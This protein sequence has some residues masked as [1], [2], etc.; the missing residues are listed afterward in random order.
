MADVQQQILDELR[1][2]NSAGGSSRRAAPS[3]PSAAQSTLGKFAEK[4]LTEL[5]GVAKG[6]A[7]SMVDVSGKFITGGA[8]ISDVSKALEANFKAAGYSGSTLGKILGSVS[9]GFNEVVKYVEEGVDA[10]RML[11][12]SGAS[13]D[14]SIIQLRQSAAN[15]RLTLDE[16]AEV[17]KNNT[18]LLASFGG[19]VNQ[20]RK[21]F[22]TLAKGLFDSGVADELRLMGY[23]NKDLNELIALQVTS[24]RTRDKL[25]GEVLKK[26]VEAARNLA[27]EMDSIAKLTGQT[28][29]EQEDKLRK[30]RE[31]GQIMAAIDAK[32]AAGGAHV[33]KAFDMMTT[34]AAAAGPDFQRLSKEIFAMGR[35]SQEMATKFSLLGGEAQKLMFQAA[36]EAAKGTEESAK[37]AKQ[38]TMEA[39]AAASMAQ[40]SETNRSLA[41]Q[42]VK[43]FSDLYI[44][45]RKYQQQLEAVAKQ[46]GLDLK[47]SEG[48]RQA[49][50][51]L[52]KQVEEE[53]KAGKDNVTK[54]AIL[55]E[56]RMADTYAAINNAL[57]TPLM[58]E[59]NPKLKGFAEELE[60]AGKAVNK[61][62]GERSGF[63]GTVEGGIEKVKDKVTDIV[64]EKE[65]YTKPTGPGRQPS[66]DR[67]VSTQ[68]SSAADEAAK[69]A[70][71]Y[72]K[73]VPIKRQGGSLGETGKLFENWGSGTLVELHG[74]ESVMK[75]ED[76]EKIVG[77]SLGAVKKTMSEVSSSGGIDVSKISKDIST[78]IS[79]APAKQSSTSTAPKMPDMG[80]MSVSMAKMGLKDDQK[81]VFD[82][83]MSLNA[84]QS[85]EKL[86][87]LK[88]EN[89]AAKKANK[90]A[91]DAR[92]VIEEKLEKEGKGIKD[93][94]GEDKKR[95]DE[96]TKQMNDSFEATKKTSDAIKIAERAEQTKQNLQKLGYDTVIKQEEDKGK[97][98]EQ[99]SEKIK[100]DIKEALPVNE[101]SEKRKEFEMTVIPQLPAK[102]L[103]GQ[104]AEAAKTLDEHGKTTLKYAMRDSD[105][106]IAAYKDGAQKTLNL[107][108]SN[109][110]EKN[111][112]ISDLE[113]KGKT[114][115]LS[116]REKSRIEKLKTE[117]QG[118]QDNNKYREQEIAAYTIAQ[119][120]K[121]K[122]LSSP[123][124][125]AANQEQEKTSLPKLNEV[126]ESASQPKTVDA[127]TTSKISQ[128]INNEFSN[129]A[130][131]V[132]TAAKNI[133][134]PAVK[135]SPKIDTKEPAV[136]E[137]DTARENARFAR[138]AES[139]KEPAVSEA[140]TA[141]ENARFA[142]QAE[143]SKLPAMDLNAL[144]LPGINFGIRSA[145]ATVAPA[146][147]KPVTDPD[148][149]RENA[150]IARQ[151]EQA[152]KSEAN[153]A[154]ARPPASTGKATL[155][156]VV[157]KLDSL[158]SNMSRLLEQTETL[159]KKQI[160]ATRANSQ[161]LFQR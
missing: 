158:N 89:E 131:A 19:T 87:S 55:A 40:A 100:N 95:F 37:R 93:L 103:S 57:V 39:A 68:E 109:I 156:D 65:E 112:Q 45:T 102:E 76:L 160:N 159:G 119:E 142:R 111:K 42:G 96:L 154:P 123:T 33:Q 101:V 5:G 30:D 85:K 107:N 140:D 23:N 56:A 20:G 32:T 129:L 69:K 59:V 128:D 99:A 81:K 151:A 133:E 58:K 48:L 114:Q 21:Q 113:E 9:G 50:E 105:E 25:E 136:S 66:P 135:E 74:M 52:Y 90:A 61:T 145:A 78:S 157:K 110:E 82:E 22:D 79:A 150:R 125:E 6:L 104:L 83:M 13:F 24:I 155:D 46:E 71:D 51:K 11:S 144:N 72:R 143:S 86:E 26:E 67:P 75:P 98:V 35:P 15:S 8:R 92:D 41:Q 43:D 130:G 3:A 53:Q 118:L 115:E 148:T 146:V 94:E 84:T 60:K 29:K 64:K 18:Q 141:R 121:K 49:Q 122:I 12:K 27:V 31:N 44:G 97:I 38:L 70:E 47:T 106:Q 73:K 14:N 91:A 17:V 152:K 80:Q 36:E 132:K 10:F 62:T 88:A 116:V 149:A 127:D 137:A 16:Y 4:G 124:P 34:A 54:T 117:I 77:S 161:N 139:S 108:K 138:Q 63:R 134:S 2:L 1:K 126:V 28:R 120:E 7:G 153:A 147:T